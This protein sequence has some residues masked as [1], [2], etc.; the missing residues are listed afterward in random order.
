M[1]FAKLVT[2]AE[3]AL[4]GRFAIRRIPS[5][6][7]FW[8]GQEVARQAGLVSGPQFRQWLQPHRV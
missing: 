7:V 2:E 8:D 5:L 4:A 1:R 3:Q 6:I